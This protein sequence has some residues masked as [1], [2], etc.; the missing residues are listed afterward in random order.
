MLGSKPPLAPGAQRRLLWP[1]AALLFR[2][3]VR[4]LRERYL[5]FPRTTSLHEVTVGFWDLQGHLLKPQPGERSCEIQRGW[6]RTLLGGSALILLPTVVCPH[7]KSL[8][9]PVGCQAALTSQ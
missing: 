9:L 6:T 3:S 7:K 5:R 4:K 8:P 1:E 2:V